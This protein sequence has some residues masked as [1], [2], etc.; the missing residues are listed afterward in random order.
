M[1]ERAE[2][3]EEERGAGRPCLGD[4]NKYWREGL[5]SRG[6]AVKKKKKAERKMKIKMSTKKR[7][8]ESERS[9][10]IG[11][12]RSRDTDWGRILR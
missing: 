8:E 3:R 11:K 4:G 1:C 7:R 9:V 6:R 2:S 10:R 5:K 12:P